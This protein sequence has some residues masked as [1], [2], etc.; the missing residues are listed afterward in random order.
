MDNETIKLSTIASFRSFAV[1]IPIVASSIAIIYDVG[2]FVGIGV[3]FFTFFSIT[4]HIV[5][6]LQ[7]IPFALSAAILI[8][9]PVL[10][11]WLGH[12][13]SQRYLEKLDA[14]EDEYSAREEL[15]QSLKIV[16]TLLRYII[17]PSLLILLIVQIYRHQYSFAFL[18]FLFSTI[19][20]TPPSWIRKIGLLRF[21]LLSTVPVAII[22]PFLI[23]LDF[24]NKILMTKAPVESVIYSDKTL[25][26]RIIRAGDKGILFFSTNDKKVRFLQWDSFKQIE[27]I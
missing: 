13:S 17:F 22:G 4:E 6:A 24:A 3:S 7:A 10:G 14:L 26:G 27:T 20:I 25:D 5:F 11:M 21:L 18:L 16:Q 15:K 9:A 12:L 19:L 8:L 23:G 2:F 1:A